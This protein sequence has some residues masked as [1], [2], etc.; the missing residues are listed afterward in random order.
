MRFAMERRALLFTLCLI[1]LSSLAGCA[2]SKPRAQ[3]SSTDEQVNAD[4]QY[5][6]GVGP[7]HINFSTLTSDNNSV[8]HTP[9]THWDSYAILYS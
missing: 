6:D 1:V 7:N 8:L 3:A 4:Q 9:R 2:D 5:P